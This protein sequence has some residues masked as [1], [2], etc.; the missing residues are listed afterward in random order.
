MAIK[1]STTQPQIDDLKE[2]VTLIDSYS[3]GGFSWIESISRLAIASLE[4]NDPNRSV[5][6]DVK[7]ALSLIQYLA[8]DHMNLINVEAENVG[9]NYISQKTKLAIQQHAANIGA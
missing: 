9:C 8:T 1:N 6:T 2:A 5:I 3:Q 7:E 4:Q